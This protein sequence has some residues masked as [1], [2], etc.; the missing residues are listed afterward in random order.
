M[1][2]RQRP[3]SSVCRIVESILR[4]LSQAATA[5]CADRRYKTKRA[6]GASP[7]GHDYRQPK[8]EEGADA[9]WQ[10]RIRIEMSSIGGR[11][12]GQ[13]AAVVLWR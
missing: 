1:A 11:L 10:V 5:R 6:S 7:T 13:C 12:F 9:F 3:V 8:V 2:E 4:S